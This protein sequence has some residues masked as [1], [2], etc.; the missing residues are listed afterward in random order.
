MKNI[1]S[2]LL[3]LSLITL[4]TNSCFKDLDTT[5]I[6]EDILTSESFYKKDGA[7][8]AVLAK[9]YAGLATTGQEGPAGQG[10]LGGIIK[11]SD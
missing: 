2:K 6:D 4:L 9:I 11:L 1:I 8:K 3:L 10:D 5:P 7:Y